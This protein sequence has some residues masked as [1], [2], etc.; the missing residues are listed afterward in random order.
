MKTALGFWKAAE[1]I[2]L[3]VVVS[4]ISSCF[5]QCPWCHGDTRLEDSM[6]FLANGKSVFVL[7]DGDHVYHY[8]IIAQT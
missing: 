8:Y 6:L 5:I 1:N 2:H 3:F 4:C 7:C